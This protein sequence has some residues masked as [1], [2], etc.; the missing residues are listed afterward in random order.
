MTGTIETASADGITTITL[1][2]EGKRN[3]ISYDMMAG[4]IDAMEDLAGRDDDHVVIVEGA[5]EHAFS[6][7]FDL[8]QS[9]EEDDGRLWQRMNDAVEAHEYPT[10]AKLNGDTYGGAFELAAT[11]DI[12]LGRRGSTFGITPAKIGVVYGPRAITRVM[13][14][15]GPA[16]S[17]ELL[18]TA[19]AIDAEH[20][21]EI[22]F[23][24]HLLEDDDA[25]D[26]RAREMAETIAG[27]AP[28]SLKRM[29]DIIHNILANRG[30]SDAEVELGHT[31][32]QEAFESRDYI[33]GVEAFSEGRD[34]EFE[35]Q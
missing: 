12:R 8:D 10:I 31:Y 5:G 35:G 6:A 7:G 16:K 27:N 11:C 19:D 25:L 1:R 18:Y 34:P 23:L 26:E 33:E 14:V 15:I 32:R 21:R 3:A 24:N 29:N 13:N 9:R 2:N 4:I 17:K 20:A 22:G 28:L 30:L